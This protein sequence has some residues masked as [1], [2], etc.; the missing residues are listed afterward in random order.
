MFRDLI[1]KLSGQF[2]I[3][4][5]ALPGF[6]QT[7]A[8]ARDQFD[9]TFDNL[10]KVVNALMEG[11]QLDR[12]AI[13]LFDYGSPTGFRLAAAH[14]ERVTAIVSQNGNAYEEGL[15]PMWALFQRY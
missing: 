5:P 8:P 2:H 4:A 7:R 10:A 13:Y 3:I 1:P 12:Y 11:L 14:P 15:G 9:Y 6:G